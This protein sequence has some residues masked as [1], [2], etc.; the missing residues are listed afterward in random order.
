MLA[1]LA[2]RFDAGAQAPRAVRIEAQGG[3]LLLHDT[4]AEALF[5]DEVG[6]SDRASGVPRLLHLP[7]GG[8]CEVDDVEA[9][10]EVLA[11]ARR[12]ERSARRKRWFK[13]VAFTLA[14]ILCIGLLAWRWATPAA[15]DV[16]A[17]RIPGSWV[18]AASAHTLGLLDQETLRPSRLPIERQTTLSNLFAGMRA[19]AGAPPYRLLF[20]H[21]G[22]AGATVM[23]LPSGDIIVTDELVELMNDDREILA[24]LAHELGHLRYQHSLKRAVNHTAL[25]SAMASVWGDPDAGAAA[26]AEGML[27]S[28]C[29]LD[30]ERAADDFAV[31]MLRANE[32]DDTVLIRALQLLAAQPPRDASLPPF[33]RPSQFFAARIEALTA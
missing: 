22:S 30:F 20:R 3:A 11:R 25:A 17:E 19:P 23:S 15:A 5:L 16:L 8:V 4:R 9:L 18:R 6:L 7:D 27:Q 13:A 33:E 28:D 14:S 32:M 10:D 29:P 26:L 12:E 21:G 1:V 2:R 24:M 31:A